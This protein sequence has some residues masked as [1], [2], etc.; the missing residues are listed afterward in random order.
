[1]CGGEHGAGDVCVVINIVLGVF[2]WSCNSQLIFINNAYFIF[3][4][5][6]VVSSVAVEANKRCRALRDQV[7]QDSNYNPESVFKLLLHT[8]QFEFQLK[9]VS[10][11]Y[12]ISLTVLVY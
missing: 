2:L 10:T 7:L 9:E 11:I 12:H 4:Q 8:A 6:V 1:M 5:I 3:S